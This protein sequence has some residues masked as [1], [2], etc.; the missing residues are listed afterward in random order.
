MADESKEPKAWRVA[1][2]KRVESDEIG[3]G[4]EVFVTPIYYDSDEEGPKVGDVLV[5]GEVKG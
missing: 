3:E 5:P 2:V 1:K 4:F